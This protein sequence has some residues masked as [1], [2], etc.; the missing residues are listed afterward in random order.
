MMDEGLNM[1]PMVSGMRDKHKNRGYA[2][3][4]F[5]NKYKYPIK[6]LGPRTRRISIQPSSAG[7]NERRS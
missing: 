2:C 5:E 7:V 1:L 6:A 4:I 3:Q